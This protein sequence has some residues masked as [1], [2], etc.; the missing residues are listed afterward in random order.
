[1]GRYVP[2]PIADIRTNGR[3]DGET[4]KERQTDDRTGR[5]ANRQTDRQT[6]RHRGTIYGQTKRYSYKR[7]AATNNRNNNIDSW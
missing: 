3:T 6:D 4:Q 5:Q 7:I 2:D 1:M